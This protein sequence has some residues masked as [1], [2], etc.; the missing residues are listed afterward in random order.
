MWRRDGLERDVMAWQCSAVRCRGAVSAFQGIHFIAHE[1]PLPFRL[2]DAE[3]GAEALVAQGHTGVIMEE[4]PDVGYTRSR[5]HVVRRSTA[6]NISD[7]PG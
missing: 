5:F 1:C 2:R 6:G 3:T 7:P 4:I